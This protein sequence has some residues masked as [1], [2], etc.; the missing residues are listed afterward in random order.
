[1]IANL[2]NMNPVILQVVILGLLGLGILGGYRKGIWLMLFRIAIFIGFLLVVALFTPVLAGILK[3]NGVIENLLGD[4]DLA[5]IPIIGGLVNTILDTVYNVISALILLV[6]GGIVNFILSIVFGFIFA[7]KSPTTR[8]LGAG[9]G[10]LINGT[11]AA[12][13]LIVVSSP[14]LFEDGNVWI[15]RSPGVKEFNTLVVGVQENLLCNNNLPCRIEDF[16]AL[17]LGADLTQ[18]AN[19]TNT[20]NNLTSIISDPE[21]YLQGAVN[22]D[23]SFNEEGL[24]NILNDLAV[25]VE[26]ASTFGLADQFLPQFEPQIQEF[27]NQLPAGATIEVPQAAIDNLQSIVDNLNMDPALEAQLQNIIN[28]QL[29]PNN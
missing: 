12:A 6:V 16:I 22:P 20:I 23:G 11:V 15:D 3:S 25:M 10:F 2:G 29:I 7:K 13:I 1:M 24:L 5:N 18:L 17:G 19:Y 26:I 4:I 8:A 9:L 28:N 21:A 27:V 14:L